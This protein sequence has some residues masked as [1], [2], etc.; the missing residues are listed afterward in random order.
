MSSAML[1]SLW[2]FYNCP[3]PLFELG[4]QFLAEE[5]WIVEI[6][7][8]ALRKIEIYPLKSEFRRLLAQVH[9]PASRTSPPL[10]CHATLT[11]VVIDPV[12]QDKIF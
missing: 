10:E 5:F 9:H 3:E 7:I 12:I 2:C 4:C 11:V 1:Y 6:K 8:F